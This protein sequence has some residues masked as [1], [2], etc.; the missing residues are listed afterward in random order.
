MIGLR[1]NFPGYYLRCDIDENIVLFRF[2]IDKNI[3]SIVVLTL[4]HGV[5]LMFTDDSYFINRCSSLLVSHF[6]HFHFHT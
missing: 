3:N 5:S 6:K 1:T 2:P 4:T